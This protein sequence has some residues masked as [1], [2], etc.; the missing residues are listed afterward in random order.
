MV[1]IGAILE[2]KVTGLTNFGA[3]V[4]LPENATGMVHISEVASTYVSDI[5]EY[6]TEN[7]EVKVK[8]IDVTPEGKIS[9][10]IKK[11][12]EPEQTERPVRRNTQNRSRANANVWK[13]SFDS[14]KDEPASFEDMMAKFKQVSDEK[15]TDLKRATDGKRN[16]YSRKK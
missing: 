13:G 9:L 15:M 6:L 7:Q 10:S 3:F 8:V 12:M 11:A 2:G 14:K 16:S 5:H 4:S 1:E